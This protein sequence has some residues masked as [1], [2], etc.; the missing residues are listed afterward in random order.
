M[1]SVH[2]SCFTD[3]QGGHVLIVLALGAARVII[4][5]A[6]VEQPELVRQAVRQYGARIAVG[7]D[8]KDGIVKTRGWLDSSGL[9]YLAFA[10]QMESYGVKTIIFTD[11]VSEGTLA[12]PCMPRL[13]QLRAAVSCG[14]V[15][16]G[17]VTTMDDLEALSRAGI[18]AAILGKTLYSG[19]LDLKTA[20]AAYQ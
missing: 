13:M 15:A 7:I 17:G 19:A 2:A 3:L 16:S 8:A 4:G 20:C 12:G 10:R 1:Q 6:A 14:I 5:S 18:D 11:I 9:D